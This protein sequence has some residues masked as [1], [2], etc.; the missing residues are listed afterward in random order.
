LSY[1]SRIEAEQAVQSAVLEDPARAS[2][3]TVSDSRFIAMAAQAGGFDFAGSL[4]A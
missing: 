4:P 1:C 2:K 3:A